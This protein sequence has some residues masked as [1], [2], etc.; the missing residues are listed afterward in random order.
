MAL[1][2]LCLLLIAAI[3]AVA[4]EPV[5][6]ERDDCRCSSSTARNVTAPS[7]QEAGLRLDRREAA[8]E[9]GDVGNTIVAG[10]SA[11]SV[12]L[13][14]LTGASEAVS[15]MPLDRDPLPVEQIEIV[16]ALDRRRRK[17]AGRRAGR[18]TDKR[19]GSLGFQSST[20][21][22]VPKVKNEAW[23]HDDVDRFILARARSRRTRS[24]H[25]TPIASRSCAA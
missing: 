11:E 14:A 22:A 4:V 6:F 1:F 19:R 7:K 8:I 21:A 12:L 15:R 18:A 24:R 16:Q 9:G 5:D 13:H 3:P 20:A 23:P 2:L 17:L 25:P 10:R